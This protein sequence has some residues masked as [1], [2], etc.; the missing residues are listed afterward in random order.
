V[1]DVY[2]AGP[3]SRQRSK[4]GEQQLDFG[5]RQVRRRLVEYDQ[6]C[7]LRTS[8]RPIMIRR[9]VTGRSR[10]TLASRNSGEAEVLGDSV[11]PR[12]PRCSPPP[13]QTASPP[14]TRAIAGRLACMPS[15]R[16]L[17]ARQVRNDHERLGHLGDAV[18]DRVVRAAEPDGLAVQQRCRRSQAFRRR[19]ACAS[20]STFPRHCVPRAQGSRALANSQRDPVERQRPRIALGKFP[21]RQEQAERRPWSGRVLAS[22]ARHFRAPSR[23]RS[24]RVPQRDDAGEDQTRPAEI[25]PWKT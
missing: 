19:S 8:A 17:A 7:G 18:R 6:P 21:E 13:N 3:I 23:P 1:R 9:C 10:P 22:V 24:G 2:D 14:S 16:V 4:D 11:Q 5:P 12:P 20:A 25:T 15:R